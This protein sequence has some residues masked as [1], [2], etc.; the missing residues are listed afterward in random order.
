MNG[1]GVIDA[2]ET[3]CRSRLARVAEHSTILWRDPTED[4]V[5]EAAYPTS[6]TAPMWTTA[7]DADQP[8]RSERP[9][10]ANPEH[11]SAAPSRQAEDVVLNRDRRVFSPAHPPGEGRADEQPGPHRRAHHGALHSRV[12]SPASCHLR[13]V[14]RL[15]GPDFPVEILPQASRISSARKRNRRGATLTALH[16]AA[17]AT[18]ARRRSTII[19]EPSNDA[20]RLSGRQATRAFGYY[21]PATHAQP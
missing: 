1:A 3:Y 7:T 21:C 14:G 18:S 10:Q 16:R 13:S 17:W 12:A 9:P 5:W 19:L 6:R 20:E 2:R 15:R 8:K 11:T 4:D